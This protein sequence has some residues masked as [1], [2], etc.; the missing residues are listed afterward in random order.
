MAYTTIDKPSDYF[1]TK[2]YVGNGGANAQTGIG[3]APN[4]V[5]IKNRSGADSHALYDTVRG[6]NKVLRSNNTNAEGSQS[7]GL[8]AF[9][10]DGFTVNAD[11]AVNTNGN[12]FVS[13]NWKAGTSVSGNTTGSGTAK[14]YTGSVSTTAGFS[15]IAYTGNGTAGHTIPHHLSAVPNIVLTKG[16]SGALNWF[17]FDSM[18]SY[19][20]R[21]KLNTTDAQADTNGLNDTAPTSSVFTVSDGGEG[22]TNGTTYVAYLFAEKKGYSKFGN[23]AGNGNVD[24]TFVYTGFKPSFLLIK[25][26]N[27]ADSWR[28]FDNKRTTTLFNPIDITQRPNTNNADYT[29]SANNVDFLSNGF[30]MRTTSGGYNGS[31]DEIIFMAFAENPFVTSTGV[32]ATAR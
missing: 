6:A 22:N 3:F 2:L 9:G 25:V 23:Y 16:R 15:I 11:G 7:D 12:N 27:S 17:F 13:W 18:S 29:A 31:S 28:L 20:K 21:L 4:W 14:A 24:G 32:P 19:L 10:S 5:W 26:T 1:V 8:T 30:K